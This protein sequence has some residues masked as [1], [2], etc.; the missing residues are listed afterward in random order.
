[1]LNDH[2]TSPHDLP[3]EGYV[4]LR[5]VL[6]VYPVSRATWYAGI[7]DG[8]FPSPVKITGTKASAWR[9]DDIRKLIERVSAQADVP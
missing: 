2:S 3:L 1:M 9:V 5:T 4:R 7:K 8:K 6:R